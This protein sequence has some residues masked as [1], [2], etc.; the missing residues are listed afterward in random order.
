MKHF[1]AFAVLSL[2]A[3]HAQAAGYHMTKDGRM[4]M[5]DPSKVDPETNT[6]EY[7]DNAAYEYRRVNLNDVSP[8]TKDTVKGIKQHRYALM[9][10]G[11]SLQP[12]MVWHVFQNGMTYAGCRTGEGSQ[13]PGLARPQVA[14]FALD[15]YY[16][17]GEIPEYR[18]LKKKQ[19]VKLV[20]GGDECESERVQIE[21]LFPNGKAF[22]HKTGLSRLDTS[23]PIRKYQ[24]KL[25]QIKD[26]QVIE[27][28]N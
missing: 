23:D 19:I 11:K 1:F 20:E 2:I 22:V 12:C 4:I 16:L 14:N 7:Y 13:L 8:E 9:N 24:A 21:A 5:L 15:T 18:G 25:V 28:K 3:V 27:A 26:L 10:D 6:V 17:M